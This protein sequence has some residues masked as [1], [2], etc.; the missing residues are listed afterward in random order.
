MEILIKKSHLFSSKKRNYKRL[1]FL[2]Q[3]RVSSFKIIRE[4]ES[5]ENLPTSFSYLRRRLPNICDWGLLVLLIFWSESWFS[6]S[7]VLFLYPKTFDSPEAS[8][9]SSFSAP[10]SVLTETWQCEKKYEQNK[11]IK[12]GKKMCITGRWRSCCSTVKQGSFKHLLCGTFWI[13]HDIYST[14]TQ[15]MPIAR[16]GKQIGS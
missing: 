8:A 1:S 10:R 4:K 16:S 3:L 13:W 6:A 12:R 5:R 9:R 14:L 7:S 15:Y 11:Y 2:L